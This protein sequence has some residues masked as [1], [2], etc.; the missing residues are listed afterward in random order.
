MGLK[1]IPWKGISGIRFGD[2]RKKLIEMIGEPTETSRRRGGI[3]EDSYLRGPRAIFI[4]YDGGKVVSIG[5]SG[6]DTDLDGWDYYGKT[7]EFIDRRF[8]RYDPQDVEGD[9]LVKDLGLKFS[10]VRDRCYMISLCKKGY[11]DELIWI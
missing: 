4:S 11:E 7:Y 10:M 8:M 2:G 6:S 9:L 1:L 3:V 5:F